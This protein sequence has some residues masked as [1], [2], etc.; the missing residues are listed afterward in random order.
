VLRY[1]SDYSFFAIEV[2]AFFVQNTKKDLATPQVP[3]AANLASVAQTLRF[4][5]QI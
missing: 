5:V 2:I 1:Q 4:R 3:Y